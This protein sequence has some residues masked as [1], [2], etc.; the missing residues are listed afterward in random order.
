MFGLI[1][2]T[3]AI[4]FALICFSAITFSVQAQVTAASE[5]GKKIVPIL[6]LLLDDEEKSTSPL[7]NPVTT[8]DILITGEGVAG[9]LISLSIVDDALP[10]GNSNVDG[11]DSGAVFVDEM[12]EWSCDISTSLILTEGTEITAIQ[13]EE[14]KPDS[15]PVTAI[16]QAEEVQEQSATPT[17]NPVAEGDLT[18][19]G[20]GVSAAT[21][22]LISD[23]ST[24]TC[25][26]APVTV[27]LAGDWSC[28]IASTQSQG[29]VIAAIA[30]EADKEP[31]S[32]ATTTVQAIEESAIPLIDAL[33]EIDLTITGEGV[34]GATITLTAND[35]ALACTNAPVIVD[36]AGDWS[37]N[38]TTTQ[39]AGVVISAT[40]AEL[41]KS[42]S[43]AATTIVQAMIT[44]EG[45][46][47][48]TIT[49]TTNGSELAC[50]NAPV[51][52]DMAG[53]WICNI[54]TTEAEGAVIAAIATE[55]GKSPSTAV[56]TIVQ[57]AVIASCEY[58]LDTPT[59]VGAANAETATGSWPDDSE[60][61][62]SFDLD[63]EGNCLSPTLSG[64]SDHYVSFYTFTVGTLS[65]YR[66]KLSSMTVFPYLVV[67]DEDGNTV[68]EFE[69]EQEDTLEATIEDLNG[70]DPGSY[71]IEATTLYGVDDGE[72]VEGDYTLTLERKP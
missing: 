15:E 9:S 32:A 47:G 59:L 69:P 58:T 2:S 37:C 71:T 22:T 51:T 6:F 29:A 35:S 14:G 68:A 16:V 48:A 24:L 49:L 40:A 1:K 30:T 55:S 72:E 38:I 53:V 12:G 46:S 66:L 4:L 5:N 65:S 44:G 31:S 54:A 45:V 57:A 34:S 64:F 43:S 17:I 63:S 39:T 42:P 8:D 21:I 25:I 23:G 26:N 33:T 60:P 41:G 61:S 18:I 19:T 28:S 20:E 62:E 56:T 36:M 27:G 11:D 13:K 70:I 50:T 67:L 7:I 52:V 3:K 10:C